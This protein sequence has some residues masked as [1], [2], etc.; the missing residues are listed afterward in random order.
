MANPFWETR[1]DVHNCCGVNVREATRG[2]EWAQILAAPFPRPRRGMITM[3]SIPVAQEALLRATWSRRK[4]WQI[5]A[6]TSEHLFV[7]HCNEVQEGWSGKVPTPD[8]VED[9]V[10]NHSDAYPELSVRNCRD[11]LPGVRCLYAHSIGSAIYR[12]Q[13]AEGNRKWLQMRLNSFRPEPDTIYHMALA[14]DQEFV[15]AKL[16][17]ARGWRRVTLTRNPNTGAR[18]AIYVLDPKN[19]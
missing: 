12:E 3:M 10:S 17:K 16:L 7:I 1:Y 13:Q 4:N 8:A 5:A 9:K 15:F 18:I 11:T 19:D 2:P 14:R 6:R